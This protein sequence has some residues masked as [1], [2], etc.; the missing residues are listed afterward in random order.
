MDRTIPPV[1][2]QATDFSISLPACETFQLSETNSLYAV[3][4][5]TQEVAA[6][7][8]YIPK[9]LPS[10]KDVVISK[11]VSGLLKSG[12]SQYSALEINEKVEQLGATMTVTQNN[13]FFILKLQSLS[14][15]IKK[16]LPLLFEIIKDAQFPAEELEIFRQQALQ[17]MAV[18]LKKSDFVANRT[19]DELIYGLQHPYGSYSLLEDYK[20]LSREDIITFH[21]E[22]IKLNFATFFL[23]GKYDNDLIDAIKLELGKLSFDNNSLDLT[24]IASNATAEKKHRIINDESASQGA[25][26]VAKQFIDRDHKDFAPMLFVNT[27]FGGYFGSR[28]M[29]NIREEKGY[30]YGIYSFVQQN[31]HQNSYIIATDVGKD[32]AEKAVSEIWNEMQQLRTEPVPQEELQLVK[33]YILGS[34]LGSVDGPF[35]IMSR[36][37]SLILNGRNEQDFQKSIETYKKISSEEVM[38]LASTYYQPEDFYDLIVY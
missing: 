32:V 34:I 27:L 38:E 16:L 25:I 2:K 29:S 28:L 14:R 11:A 37:K 1:I 13:D 23:S 8:I 4:A 24:A 33:N 22:Y 19:I 12:T 5:G 30:T 10:Q 36:W 21:K 20:Q 6:F 18:N 15:Y 7:E 9:L 31:L 17:H 35:K 3:N 26:R